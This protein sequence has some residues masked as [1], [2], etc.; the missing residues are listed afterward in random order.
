MV[1]APSLGILPGARVALGRLLGGS[2][3][4]EICEKAFADSQEQDWKGAIL[5]GGWDEHESLGDN[6]SQVPEVTVQP[7][8]SNDTTSSNRAV[9]GVT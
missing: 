2:G 9:V 6:D 4:H 5:D 8:P 1:L 7:H 3:H